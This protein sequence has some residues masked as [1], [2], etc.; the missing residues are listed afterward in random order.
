MKIFT[1]GNAN[2]AFKFVVIFF[3][4]INSQLFTQ[5]QIQLVPGPEI[6]PIDMVENIVGEGI[7]YDNVNFQG[8][9]IS[10]GVFSNG[11]TTNLGISSGIFLT[12]GSAFVVPGPNTQSSAGQ[13]NGT[14]G[15]ATLNSITTSTTHD[16]AV[17]TFDFV[18]ESDTL[19]FK[20]VFGS[21]EYN[22]WVGS[23]F[24]D[25]FGYFVSGPNP[26]GG[27]YS[28][29]NIA[30]VPGTTTSV[31]INNVNNGYAGA[32]TYPTGPCN[33]CAYYSDNTFGATL[34][35][36]GF[37]VV[38]EAFLLV[39][40]CETYSIKIGVADAGD[41]IY[42]SGVFIEE[43]SFESPR[44]EVESDPY[45]QGVS[46]FMIEG[47][48]EADI[49]FTLPD[50]D[51]A[52]I[53]VNFDL[54]LSTANPAAYPDGD[55]EEEIPT[56]I[57]FEEGQ[58][59]AFIHVAPV[60]DNQIEGIENLVLVIENTLGC[61]VRYDTVEFTILD[62]VAME[63]TISPSTVLC[64]GQEIQLWVQTFNGIPPYTTTWEPPGIQA[65]TITVTP[66]VTTMYTIQVLDL[67][68]DTLVDSVQV[69][70]FPTPDVDL[71]DSSVICG[72]DTL[73]LNAGGGYQGY[74]WNTGSTDSTIAVTQEGLYF[75][76]VTGPGFCSTWDSI[77]VSA[78]EVSVE[79]GEDTTKICI[80]DT[81]IFNA[82]LGYESYLWQD[83]STEPTYTGT[84]TGTV[85]VQV[86]VGGCTATD[87]VYLAVI[88]PNS[89]LS[90]G[91]DQTVCPG[92]PVVLKPLNGPYI[93][94]SWSTGDTTSQIVVTQPGT[95]SLTVSGCGTATDQINI[96]NYNTPQVNLGP[97]TI[98]C[99]ND[100]LELNISPQQFQTVQWQDN[101]EDFFYYIDQSGVYYVDATDYNGCED[102]DTINVE[103]A[104]AVDLGYDTI[105]VLCTG[106]SIQLQVGNEFDYYTWSKDQ[107]VISSGTNKIYVTSG[108]MYDVTVNYEFG[109]ESNDQV[110]VDEYPVPAADI[111]G[112]DMICA[113]ESVTLQAPEGPFSYYWNTSE[114]TTAITVSQGGDYTVT[115]ENVCGEDDATKSVVY[116]ELPP[117]DLG[118]SQILVPGS[119]ITLDA[120]SFE[121]YTW[122]AD[123]NLNSQYLTISYDQV[124]GIGSDTISV[125]V[126]DGFC[127]NKD[128]IVIEVLNIEVPIVITPNGDGAN[129]TFTPMQ[130][131]GW[132]AVRDHTIMVFNRWGEKVW[133][134]GDFLSGWDGKQNG[135][136]VADGTYYWILEVYYGNE[137]VKKVFKGTLTVVGSN[138]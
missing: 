25:V 8:A 15:D 36:D 88:D 136:Y 13:N 80:G 138:N 66:D 101:S 79:L 74:L 18:P 99:A 21:E 109:C 9:N 118:E 28:N 62:Y 20:Y 63:D 56:S 42:D 81:A 125:E 117:V 134:S 12:S 14:P 39:V 78:V 133:E 103:V 65:D 51:Y 92:T 29:K 24:N 6:T 112:G 61:I 52:P 86:T 46:D 50:A 3:I 129:D 90:L 96:S 108:G 124:L 37:T 7:I 54:S 119:S 59:T 114:T 115:M 113:G 73:W 82:G 23:S 104:N 40:P 67:C 106:D 68:E 49:I 77:Y 122:S 72:G 22:E 83:G 76:K 47:C 34:Q 102:S 75:V 128:E 95:Y 85:W 71:G 126:F 4:A 91:P 1:S 53:T 19:R 120:G 58:D 130:D 10:R 48:V 43:N 41:G 16:A 97:D 60:K 44:I 111:T 32:N 131:D 45:P 38:M 89:T 11:Q 69:T 100:I 64:Q 27:N 94:Y 2:F 55:F 123:P 30:L 121:T 127:S 105:Q 93:Y 57:T 137:N 107:N 116:H 31:T 26:D 5:A 110:Q 70:V 84:E 132:A 35:Y 17:L 87:S 135:H 98:L 33:N